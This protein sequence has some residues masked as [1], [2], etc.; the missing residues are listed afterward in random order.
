ML[1]RVSD[2]GNFPRVQA[3]TSCTPQHLLV[4]VLVLWSFTQGLVHLH[5]RAAGGV[6]AGAAAAAAAGP[7]DVAAAGRAGFL[8]AAT[9]LGF[10]AGSAL[11]PPAT[12][13]A[14][15]LV[16]CAAVANVGVAALGALTGAGYL[17]TL[18]TFLTKARATAAAGPRALA[19][20]CGA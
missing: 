18:R 13:L 7:A 12:R 17:A 15:P 19:L 14:H 16:M 4:T 1:R 20:P 6:A 10:L 5:T 3:S 11:P 8:L 9:V 2:R